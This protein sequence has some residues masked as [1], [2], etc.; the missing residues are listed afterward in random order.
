MRSDHLG[1]RPSPSV[2]VLLVICTL[3]VGCLDG[4]APE[5]WQGVG[6]GMVASQRTA[7]GGGAHKL[8]L[9]GGPGHSTYL[10]CLSCSQYSTD[11]VFN[12]YGIHGNPYSSESVYNKYSQFGGPYGAYSPCNPYASDPP[13]IVDEAGNFHGRLTVNR[14]ASQ[15]TR[16]ETI[17]AWLERVVCN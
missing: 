16:D 9:F 8:M 3:T 13:V 14:Y 7:P 4:C 1:H 15:A 5:F 2:N 10:G 12:E 11:S 6:Q 17:L